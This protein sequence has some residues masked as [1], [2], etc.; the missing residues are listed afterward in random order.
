MA[1]VFA[2]SSTL[3][4]FKLKK[5]YFISTRFPWASSGTLEVTFSLNS[6]VRVLRGG[7]VDLYKFIQLNYLVLENQNF[8][9]FTPLNKIVF[10]HR[11]NE[12]AGYGINRGEKG[13]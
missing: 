1:F 4:S 2:V 5:F 11:D 9:C 12:G 7:G 10:V 8:S 6:Q 13:A 3:G